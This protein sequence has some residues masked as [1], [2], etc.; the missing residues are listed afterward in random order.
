MEKNKKEKQKRDR[1][2]QETQDE[3]DEKEK[4]K[5]KKNRNKQRDKTY[6]LKEDESSSTSSS[7]PTKRK[8][9]RKSRKKE[10][11]QGRTR[12]NKNRRDDT[13]S[14]DQRSIGTTKT[15]SSRNETSERRKQKN[16]GKEETKNKKNDK[17][18][19]SSKENKEDEYNTRSNSIPSVTSSMDSEARMDIIRLNEERD[20]TKQLRK[21]RKNKEKEI[22]V[23]KHK[24][25]ENKKELQRREKEEEEKK[26]L[27]EK[28]KK[29]E[30]KK[31]RKMWDERQDKRDK[32]R[33]KLLR[34][35]G[36]IE[37]TR[38]EEEEAMKRTKAKAEK[39]T[40]KLNKSNQIIQKIDDERRE[41][42]MEED[43]GK[44]H[45]EQKKYEIEKEERERKIKQIQKIVQGRNRQS[46]EDR[47]IIMDGTE[48]KIFISYEDVIFCWNKNQEH[49]LINEETWNSL[50]YTNKLNW[51]DKLSKP[52]TK[53]NENKMSQMRQE[54]DN[55]D[56]RT[57]NQETAIQ[58]ITEHWNCMKCN[59]LQN[60][61]QCQNC[62][63]TPKKMNDSFKPGFQYTQFETDEEN[64]GNMKETTKFY[65]TPK[66]YNT[67]LNKNV[68]NKII[69][70]MYSTEKQKINN[71]ES[72]NKDKQMY[73][74]GTIS[75][76]QIIDV[77]KEHKLAQERKSLQKVPVINLGSDSSPEKPDIDEGTGIAIFPKAINKARTMNGTGGNSDDFEMPDFSLFKCSEFIA[78]IS[79][80]K[81]E[82]ADTYRELNNDV[83]DIQFKMENEPDKIEELT[84]ELE[85]KRKFMKQIDDLINSEDKMK[86][87][88]FQIRLYGLNNDIIT[89]E[90]CIPFDSKGFP[91][92]NGND[93]DL[94]EIWHFMSSNED[95][96][97]VE[98]DIGLVRYI[99][100]D[101]ENNVHFYGKD[102]ESGFFEVIKPE[103]HIEKAVRSYSEHRKRNGILNS[104]LAMREIRSTKIQPDNSDP[105]YDNA[106]EHY[107]KAT[108]S[109]IDD[110]DENDLCYHLHIVT[111]ALDYTQ[112]LLKGRQKLKEKTEDRQC[113]YIID[114]DIALLEKDTS[115][116]TDI[117]NK[118]NKLV[119]TK[120]NRINIQ[121][122]L[123]FLSDLN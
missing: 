12:I 45:E 89:P 16:T 30:E 82:L 114:Q 94:N 39:Q 42:Q 109:R 122:D 105:Q 8:K 67:G 74:E 15:R 35:K 110:V 99:Y 120:R 107:N 27:Y 92:S 61:R 70:T 33:E 41:Q 36:R 7:E 51:I 121:R 11:D 60:T 68:K 78:Q 81:I 25:K 79:T 116:Y 100:F 112:H 108:Q 93:K 34:M 48:D 43:E 96:I 118:L 98:G 75:P 123:N 102:D 119:I 80:T 72:K 40:K 77:E 38:A 66:T 20:Y 37:E 87:F 97:A 3:E 29:E 5:K 23:T 47:G 101:E 18:R 88:L 83:E 115:K 24:E 76:A 28:K 17:P 1:P 10:D 56:M 54:T 111:Q 59:T 58:M 91:V 52:K 63:F 64:Q 32:R 6:K 21:N 19:K 9:K 50:T 113:R 44:H 22:E 57:Q 65:T 90:Y 73:K 103:K 31:E 62:G 85:P 14:E 95:I 69:S 86:E 104:E 106:I 49:T 55:R 13:D 4:K 84:L 46:T 2:Q 117:I 26:K 53:Q 71:N